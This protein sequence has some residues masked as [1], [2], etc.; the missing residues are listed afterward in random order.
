LTRAIDRAHEKGAGQIVSGARAD[1]AVSDAFLRRRGFHPAGHERTF[2]A[3]ATL[4]FPEPA[5]PAGYTVRTLAEIEDLHVW[6]EAC[7]RCYGDMWG[8][9][10]NTEQAT[11]EHYIE[12]QRRRPDF[13]NPSGIFLVFAP[14]STV[15]GISAARLEAGSTPGVGTG[16]IDAPA[17]AP[18]YR[19]LGLL[20]PLVLSALRWLTS[21]GA[22]DYR[23]DTWGDNEAAVAVYFDLGFALADDSIEYLMQA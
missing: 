21:L 22:G 23:L 11:P 1:D 13:F 6:A 18:Q 16:I 2:T 14:D 3:P 17:V 9:R 15:M 7:N 20:R 12:I 19:H 5:W 4:S 10:E 8:H